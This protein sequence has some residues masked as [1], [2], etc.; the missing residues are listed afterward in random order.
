MNSDADIIELGIHKGFLNVNIYIWR[1]STHTDH[2]YNRAHLYHL[3][4]PLIISANLIN[5]MYVTGS[6]K[7]QHFVDYIKIEILLLFSI[8]NVWV[9][10]LLSMSIYNCTISE[11]QHFVTQPL[12]IIANIEGSKITSAYTHKNW[13]CWIFTYPVTNDGCSGNKYLLIKDTF[14]KGAHLQGPQVITKTYVYTCIYIS[15][16]EKRTPL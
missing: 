12:I 11:L 2:H 9:T 5:Y 13:K 1:K 8:Y 15:P 7:I 6:G 16:S 14:L 3:W 4:C 10:S